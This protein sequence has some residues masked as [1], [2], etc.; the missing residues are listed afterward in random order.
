MLDRERNLLDRAGCL[1]EAGRT[2]EALGLLKTLK[3]RPSAELE[4]RDMWQVHELFGACFHD[5]GDAEGAAQAY[6]QAARCDRFLRSQRQHF[7]SYLFALHYLSGISDKEMAEQNLSYGG[8]YRDVEPLP[9]RKA[10]RPG[11][12]VRVGYLA[13]SF[14]EQAAMRFYEIM[15]TGYD[16][17]RFEVCCYGLEPSGARAGK[18][19]Q[20]HVGGW[21]E[22][23]GM[24]VE[25]AASLIQR[26]GVDILFD[27]GG[28]S[29][30]GMTLM[31]MA[32]H[33]ARVQVSGI[34]WMDTTGLPAMDY[35]LADEALVPGDF[36]GAYF[37]EKLLFLPHAFCWQP[38]EEM[39][40]TRGSPRKKGGPLRLGCFNNFMK[41]TET[42]LCVWRD[43]LEELPGAVLVLQDVFSHPARQ[44][45]MERRIQAAGL[46]GRV[47]L[48][49]ASPGY[50][51]QLAETDVILDTFPYNGGGM[52]A[53]ALYMGTPVVTL[54]GSR[55]GSRF[56]AA[57][58]RSAGLPELIA[59][60]GEEYVRK[61]VEL[62]SD[63]EGLRAYHRNLRRKM[64]AS[65]LMDGRR[66]MEALEREYLRLVQL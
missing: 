48:H 63:A 6:V 64:E 10:E 30:G 14:S 59:E 26:D 60:T 28:H 58:L 32:Y 7:S 57:I 33:P 35:L 50:L 51:D 24:G 54:A 56:G 39:R 40:N 42:A 16:R 65:P 5:M 34:G 66:Y 19:L 61:A 4:E 46:A 49:P 8:L 23:S 17:K 29:E 41:V 36:A 21:K 43:I 45:E 38:T 15:L 37:S 3:E 9:L 27:L 18:K 1:L 55:Y 47:E 44:R 11:G 53:A 62:A 31:I 20:A 22:L 12:K 52:T 2:E 25:E 13:P